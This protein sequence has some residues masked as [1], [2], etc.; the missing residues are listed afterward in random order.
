MGLQLASAGPHKYHFRQSA[1]N[2]VKRWMRQELCASN[3]QV[4]RSRVC[5]FGA[6]SLCKISSLLFPMTFLIIS[7]YWALTHNL[8]ARHA[9]ECSVSTVSPSSCAACVYDESS[10]QYS[11]D[12][13]QGKWLAFSD[14]RDIKCAP[15]LQQSII[16]RDAPT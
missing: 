1:G 10:S 11:L 9:L 14:L 6:R 7:L 13:L 16:G 5:S 15:R 2:R 3:R 8:C 12:F 4:K